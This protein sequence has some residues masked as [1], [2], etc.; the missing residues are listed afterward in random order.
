MP[1]SFER[2]GAATRAGKLL[3]MDGMRQ[4]RRMVQKTQQT[5]GET[6][7]IIALVAKAFVVSNSS[8]N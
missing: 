3:R 1:P 2:S 5:P 6:A 4:T 7:L 8:T